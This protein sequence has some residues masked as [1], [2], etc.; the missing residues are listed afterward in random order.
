MA[1]CGQKRVSAFDPHITA[2]TGGAAEIALRPGNS[3]FY[4]RVEGTGGADRIDHGVK[5]DLVD[6]A[7]HLVGN[8]ICKRRN[9]SS[10]TALARLLVA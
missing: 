8:F 3:A 1:A 9:R 4:P 2:L 7:A 6:W 10:R 5:S